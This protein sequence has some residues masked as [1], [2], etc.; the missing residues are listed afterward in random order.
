MMKKEDALA[1]SES[2]LVELGEAL[3]EGK[4]EEL[5]RF[6]DVMSGFYN[7]SFGNC[8]LIAQ[9]FPEATYVAGFR[10]WLKRGRAV[11]K[12][13]KG[14]CILAPLIRKKQDEQVSETT[15]DNERELFGYRAVHVFDVSQTE[16]DE[17]PE[18][19]HVSGDP[20]DSLSQLREVVRKRGIELLYEEEL[21]GARGLSK[22]GTIC[23]LSGMTPAEEFAVLAHEVAHEGLHKGE[24]RKDTTK[25]VRELEA[26][27]VSYVVAKA[28][29]LANALKHS[30]DYIQLYSGDREKLQNSLE[31]IQKTASSILTEL[32]EVSVPG[33][34]PVA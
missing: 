10:A 26:E 16:G 27:A 3:N 21:G 13:E 8:M 32:E 25:V 6:L 12:G 18:I 34:V 33:N 14:I 15:G 5:T 2:A 7:Y 29:R 30:S 20:G 22:G 1:L 4:S 28:F 19:N 17:L 23:L 9:Q 24:D 31:R 11:K